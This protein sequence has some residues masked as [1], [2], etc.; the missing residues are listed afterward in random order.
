MLTSRAPD[1]LSHACSVV[2]DLIYW[3]RINLCSGLKPNDTTYITVSPMH[4]ISSL[5]H[6]SCSGLKPNDTTYI[7]FGRRGSG[8]TTIR[9][10]ME[11]G[12]R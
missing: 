9:L 3:S 1:L 12:Y 2:F 6:A 10:Q 4:L 8:K 5:T 11:A 7:F